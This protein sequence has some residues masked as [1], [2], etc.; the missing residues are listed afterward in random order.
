MCFSPCWINVAISGHTHQPK[1]ADRFYVRPSVQ[2]ITFQLL[3]AVG[4][5]PLM[6]HVTLLH[7]ADLVQPHK[8]L[9]SLHCSLT[10]FLISS[11]SGRC[12]LWCK[13]N[14]VLS[15]QQEC[16]SC[17][18]TPNSYCGILQ[19]WKTIFQEMGL[20]ICPTIK[21]EGDGDAWGRVKIK[22]IKGRGWKRMIKNRIKVEQILS[23]TTVCFR[24]RVHR[25][26]FTFGTD[27]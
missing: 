7:W 6:Q 16:S 1:A 21:E 18:Q 20:S 13:L 25:I 24:T 19:D 2:S 10:C 23:S 15:F 5:C 3:A 14:Y 22:M 17:K 11:L 12:W 26:Y 9:T 27:G 4:V 8:M